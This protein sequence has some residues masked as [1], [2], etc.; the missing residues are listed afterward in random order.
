MTTEEM[1]QGL[2]NGTVYEKDLTKND[3]WQISGHPG[4][5]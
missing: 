1:I 5:S 4:L 2:M 3:W